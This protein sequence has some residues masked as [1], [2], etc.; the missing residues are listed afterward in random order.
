MIQ[1]KRWKKSVERGDGSRLLICRYRLRGVRKADETWGV[2]W[3]DVSR[4][5]G[6]HANFY[7]KHSPPLSWPE[8]KRRYLSDMKLQLDRISSLPAGSRPA[9]RSCFSAPP[10]ATI[11]NTDAECCSKDWSNGHWQ[12]SRNLTINP[13][14]CQ[15]GD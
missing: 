8:Y 4:S 14:A 12:L 1:T 2:W 7:G 6:V 10:R 3:P 9:K 5:H 11:R 13:R 15:C